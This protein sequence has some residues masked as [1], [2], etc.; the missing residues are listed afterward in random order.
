MKI[1]N[2]K[3]SY[4]DGKYGIGPYVEW[5]PQLTVV[6]TNYNQVIMAL[7]KNIQS[8]KTSKFYVFQNNMDISI[9]FLPPN[10]KFILL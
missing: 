6:N 1:K 9:Q 8:L 10:G 3:F 4:V 5:C 2:V 7:Q